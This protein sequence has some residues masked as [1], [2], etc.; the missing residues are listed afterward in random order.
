MRLKAGCRKS[1]CAFEAALCPWAN[2]TRQ[3]GLALNF[4]HLSTSPTCSRLIRRFALLASGSRRNL[5]FRECDANNGWHPGVRIMRPTIVSA[6]PQ[7]GHPSASATLLKSARRR[8]L[9]VTC[10]RAKERLTR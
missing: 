5:G 6:V 10:S 7:F 4:S 2:R 8:G 1:H 3:S 9:M